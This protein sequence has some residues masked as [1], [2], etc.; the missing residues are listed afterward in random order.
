MSCCQ[1]AEHGVTFVETLIA[2]VVFIAILVSVIQLFGYYRREEAA[3]I[4]RSGCSAKFMLLEER[5]RRDM[6]SAGSLQSESL[7]AFSLLNVLQEDGSNSEQIRYEFS[8]QKRQVIRISGIDEKRYSFDDVTR[9]CPVFSFAISYLD[10]TGK[11]PTAP[12]Q[13]V[14]VEVTLLLAV[15]ESQQQIFSLRASRRSKFSESTPA[16][17]L[18]WKD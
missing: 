7:Q 11:Q 6:A 2:F 8:D 16:E 10:A 5:L 14:F 13:A 4:M 15:S 9:G 3:A 12:E 17:T 18:I 1:R